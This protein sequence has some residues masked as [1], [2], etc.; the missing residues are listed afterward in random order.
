MVLVITL[1][2]IKRL[3][4]QQTGSSNNAFG[5]YALAGNNETGNNAFGALA[6]EFNFT[7]SYN[8]AMGN[9]ALATSTGSSN[10]AQ[11]AGAGG[12]QQT[13]SNSIY[14]G[15]AGFFDESNVIAIGRTLPNAIPYENTYIGGIYDTVVTDRI[16][17]V[18]SD[19]HLGTLLRRAAIKRKSSPWTKSVKHSSR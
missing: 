8:T 10:I 14:I 6:L 9:G 18:G 15:D 11:G 12:F 16:V 1:L 17:Y 5:Y 7:G 19:G 13:G 4:A 2:V 3:G